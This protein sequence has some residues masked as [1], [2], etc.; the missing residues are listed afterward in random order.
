MI[1]R[2]TAYATD[3][4]AGRVV[5]GPWVRLACERH[6]RDLEQGAA[7]G[8]TFDVQLAARAI[9][10]IECLTLADGEHAG[11]PFTLQPWQAFVVGSLFGWLAPDGFRRFRTAYVEIGKGN[12]K[13]PMAAA[14]ALYLALA[15]GETGAEVY[16]A[17]VS[18]DQAKICFRDVQR[19]AEASPALASRLKVD[20]QNVAHHAS[21]SYIRPVSSE[22]RG[23]D[24]KRV[25]GA[26]I[27]EIHE[28]QTSVVVDK[29]RAGTKGR[30]Q[31]L[32][33]EITNSGYDRHSVCWDH[34]EY[35]TKVVQG[36]VENDSWFGYV[37][38]LDEGDD[39]LDDPTCWVKAN[40][41][42]GVSI[43]EKYLQE[44][45]AEARD[46]PSKRNIVARLLFCVW[47]EQSSV[48]VPIEHWD[49]GAVPLN[50]EQLRGRECFGGLDLASTADIAAHVLVFPPTGG[51]RWA[52]LPRFWC[53][54]DGIRLRSR[55]D[56]VPYDRWAQE[57]HI[58]ATDGNQID[59][60]FLRDSIQRDAE[61]YRFKGIAFDRWNSSH[62]VQELLADGFNMLG[63]GQGFASM[64]APVRELQR[65]IMS[66]Q[67]AHGGHPVLRWMISNIAAA[68]D[69]AGNE[70]FDKSKSGDKIDGAVA[71]AMA[72]GI[73]IA[74]EIKG[75]SVYETRGVLTL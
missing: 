75:P 42:L 6:L 18:R 9:A 64:A 71:L 45:V 46:I 66:E 24:G 50:L 73:A 23:L 74:D 53:P 19:F 51:E 56:G 12:G 47:T 72:L 16:T 27:D 4:V 67:I 29:M 13:T 49:K 70:K 17:A 8:L 59:Y 30:R 1:D 69:P 62:L 60:A 28:H 33:V 37:A 44:Q 54:Q 61:L 11:Q 35:S 38:A 48:W 22:G 3:V 21:G 41:N 20:A 43:T 39:W 15:D 40:P 10:F 65:L 14:I 63:F 34:H 58:V 52:V 57:G 32:I 55:R 26:L 68:Q 7:R 5:A 31:A 2:T 36:I 25:H